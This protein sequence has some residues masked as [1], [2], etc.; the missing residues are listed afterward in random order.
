MLGI[1]RTSEDKVIEKERRKPLNEFGTKTKAK[2]TFNRLWM[3]NHLWINDPDAL[4]I[5]DLDGQHIEA[6][7]VHLQIATVL[8]CGGVVTVGDRLTDYSKEDQ[9]LLRRIKDYTYYV[10][11]VT[12]DEDY[13]T[14]TLNLKSRKERIKIYINWTEANQTILIGQ[15]SVNFMNNEPLSSEYILP[16]TDTLIVI[17]H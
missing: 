3:N 4:C 14:F 11:E 17:E 9:A 15:N 8:I 12:A 5:K 2:E 13:S 7:D 6:N 1:Q 10:K 16:P